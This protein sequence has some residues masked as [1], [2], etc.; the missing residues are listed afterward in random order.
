MK[1]IKIGNRHA[2][3]AG[4]IIEVR[5]DKSM[6]KSKT[7]ILVM[8]KNGSR[9]FLDRTELTPAQVTTE[10]DNIINEINTAQV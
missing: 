10:F 5:I 2:I 1:L 6:D 3:V 7:G 9:V 8:S 4:D